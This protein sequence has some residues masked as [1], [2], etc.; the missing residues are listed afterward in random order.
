MTMSCDAERKATNTAIASQ[1]IGRLGGRTESHDAD[2]DG[3]ASLIN[4][5]PTAAPA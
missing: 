3:Q 2:A 5:D 4:Q 1:H